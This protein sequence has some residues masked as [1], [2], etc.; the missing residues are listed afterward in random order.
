MIISVLIAII[1]VA[2]ILVILMSVKGSPK[3][4]KKKEL[5]DKI[6]RKGKSNI[7]RDAEKKLAHDPKHVPSLEVLGKLYF[8]E[9]NWDKVYSIYKTLY[10]LSTSQIGINRGA[11]ALNYGIAYEIG[12]FAI[13]LANHK[14]NVEN[15]LNNNGKD[16]LNLSLLSTKY[17]ITK[18]VDF[19]FS[20]GRIAYETENNISSVGVLST[21]GFMINF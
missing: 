9:K 8:D 1:V 19:A 12:P 10:D 11:V 5:G 15:L 17:S 13:S 3:N 6:Q 14:S 16:T 4:R 20:V 18:G 2:L 21:T 7:V